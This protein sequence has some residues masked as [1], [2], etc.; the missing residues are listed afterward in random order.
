MRAGAGMGVGA[1]AG[2]GRRR[3][4][5]A[6]VVVLMA[7]AEGSEGLGRESVHVDVSGVTMLQVTPMHHFN[8]ARP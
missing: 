2:G 3:R 6:A 8:S 1:D 4:P 7:V 5:T